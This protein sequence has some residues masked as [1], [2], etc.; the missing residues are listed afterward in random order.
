MAQNEREARRRRYRAAI[1]AFCLLDD[2]FMTAV[3]QD[4]LEC[5]NLV[6][7]IILDNPELRAESVI[8]QD[9]MKNLQGHSVRL[10]IHAFADGREFNIEIQRA[11][12]GA[13]E[14]R[15]RYNSSIMDANALAEGK[16]Y[17]HL[18]ESYV[19][20]ITETDVLGHGRPI[21]RIR[22]AIE[23]TDASFND[24][25]HIVYV[26]SAV[27][28]PDTPLGKLMHDFRCRRP[29]EMYYDVLAR[30]TS[31]FKY[32]V[33]GAAQMTEAEKIIQK[34]TDEAKAEAH[35]EG[36]QQGMQQG[37]ESERIFSIKSIMKNLELTAEKAMDILS[38]PKAEQGK[39]KAFL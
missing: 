16:S 34:I 31:Y 1:E 22:R 27:T 14:R 26:N 32:D 4:N 25:S 20:F 35:T 33:K 3:F 19:I 11:G 12:S 10:D 24:G 28:D 38:I 6:I 23:G 2:A 5:V 18:P 21:Y 13:S 29:E 15:A 8:T 17:E 9:T 7:Q 36:L 39:Y 37:K 30:R